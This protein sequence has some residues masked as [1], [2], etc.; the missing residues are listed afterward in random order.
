MTIAEDFANTELIVMKGQPLGCSLRHLIF[1]K[2][3]NVFKEVTLQNNHLKSNP[4]TQL[5]FTLSII[6]TWHHVTHTFFQINYSEILRSE[7]YS[8][9]RFGWLAKRLTGTL[10]K[11]PEQCVRPGSE[12][13]LVSHT[14][15]HYEAALLLHTVFFSLSN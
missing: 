15:A 10:Q 14:Y 13:A 11:K 9:L 12:A 6:L 3:S 5:A 2:F 4:Y 7:V 8:C 1:P